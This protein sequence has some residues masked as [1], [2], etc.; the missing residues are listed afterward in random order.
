MALVVVEPQLPDNVVELPGG[1][2]LTAQVQ[3]VAPQ[4]WAFFTRSPRE[5]KLT[6]WQPEGQSWESAMRAPHAE[7]GNAFG[8]DRAS[9]AQPV[10]AAILSAQVPE[11]A[12]TECNSTPLR[13]CLEQEEAATAV[14]GAQPE[15]S[16]CGRL[17]LVAQEPWPWAWAES[18]GQ[19][20]MPA[21]IVRLDVAC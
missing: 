18:S 20:E 16:L 15:P 5:E 14:E 13:R 12:W 2:E 1:D 4:G 6:A 21:R 7:P 10:E 17:A 11:D 3:A 8:L 9:R 19:G